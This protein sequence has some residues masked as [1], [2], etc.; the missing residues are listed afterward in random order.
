MKKLIYILLVTTLLI[1]SY[2]VFLVFFSEETITPYE[3][4]AD[5]LIQDDS[6]NKPLIQAQ[7]IELAKTHF[8][9]ENYYDFILIENTSYGTSYF[10]FNKTIGMVDYDSK[11]YYRAVF[12]HEYAHYS[13][14]KLELYNTNLHE[15]L[16][17]TYEF[18]LNKDFLVEYAGEDY[19][20][21]NDIYPYDYI[22]DQ[23]LEADNFDCLDKVFSTKI[24]SIKEY[25]KRLES[26]CDIDLDKVKH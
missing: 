24:D 20:L 12:D 26:K 18:Y 5:L 11:D 13:M 23:I 6:Y 4:A 2:N 21:N 15:A 22:L 16:A 1:T 25:L 17:E 14:F 19:Y 3:I 7:Q 8:E 9:L 10:N